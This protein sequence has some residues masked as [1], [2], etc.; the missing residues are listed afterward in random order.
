MSNVIKKIQSNIH[1]SSNARAYSDECNILY[2]GISA[3]GSEISLTTNALRGN[4]QGLPRIMILTLG[5][6][7]HLND[8]RMAPS[9]KSIEMAP[10][11]LLDSEPLVCQ[12]TSRRRGNNP[13]PQGLDDHDHDYFLM[14]IMK[15]QW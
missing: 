10:S 11:R 1:K 13:V 15:H 3:F 6:I 4:R 7:L 5:R 9:S 8:T 2:M 14:C 12:K